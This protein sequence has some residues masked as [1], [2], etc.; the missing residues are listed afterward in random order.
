MP[1][2]HYSICSIEVTATI[3][4]TFAQAAMI[5]ILIY[6]RR[7]VGW[8]ESNSLCDRTGWPDPAYKL[9]HPPVLRERKA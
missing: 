7:H 8:K 4:A 9:L 3:S 5:Y 2:F 1:T 6:G